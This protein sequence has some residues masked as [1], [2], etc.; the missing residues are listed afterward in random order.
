MKKLLKVVGIFAGVVVVLVVIAAVVVP[1]V[2]DPNDYKEE[3]AEAVKKHTG[4]DLQISGKIALT[5]FPWLGVDLGR[6]VLGNATGFDGDHFASTERV[7]VRVKV[8]PLLQGETEMDTIIVEGLTLNLQRNADGR[9]N[10]DD[11]LESSGDEAEE[12]SATPAVALAIGGIKLSE[13]TI[14]WTDALTESHSQIENLA[15]DTGPRVTGKPDSTKSLV[16]C[17]IEPASLVRSRPVGR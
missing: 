11:L 6:V 4:R 3:I 17:S 9:T 15:M 12:S 10:V 14:S 2:F 1:L 8:A 16:Q 7:Q 5:M 13:S